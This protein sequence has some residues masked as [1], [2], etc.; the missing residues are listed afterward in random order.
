[1]TVQDVARMAKMQDTLGLSKALQDENAEV[2]KAAAMALTELG[3]ADAVKVLSNCLCADGKSAA[4]TLAAIGLRAIG[5]SSF[6]KS[7]RAHA[8]IALKKGLRSNDP[9]AQSCAAVA[10]SDI[11]DSAVIRCL[12]EAIREPES[13][14]RKAASMALARIGKPEAIAALTAAFRA[15]DAVARAEMALVLQDQNPTLRAKLLA[16]L[17]EGDNAILQDEESRSTTAGKKSWWHFWQ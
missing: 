15:G 1:M 4:R 3:N 5:D 6:K 12:S 17:Q 14:T 2:Q 13:N 8:I 9:D 10:L 7:G 16:I 11:G